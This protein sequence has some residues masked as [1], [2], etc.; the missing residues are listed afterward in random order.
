MHQHCEVVFK[1]R[2]T[3]G[4][5]LQLVQTLIGSM[6]M[7]MGLCLRR[8]LVKHMAVTGVEN[9]HFEPPV[10]YFWY[11]YKPMHEKYLKKTWQ[12]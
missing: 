3:H 5:D 7:S 10:F 2:C 11:S 4:L 12:I 8:E 9:S 1:S 6:H